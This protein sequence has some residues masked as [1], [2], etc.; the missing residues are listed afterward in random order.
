M[1]LNNNPTM[2][3][4]RELLRTAD[5]RA[6]RHVLWADHKG[7]VHLTPIPGEDANGFDREH[8]DARMWLREFEAGEAFV[9]PLAAADRGWVEDLFVALT[10]NWPKAS[11]RA[12]ALAVEDW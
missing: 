9:G 8:P 2:D 4:L 12:E 1:N 7:E 5:D 11:A 10:R 3:Q 6:G